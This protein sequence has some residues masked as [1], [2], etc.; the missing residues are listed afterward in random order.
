MCVISAP[1]L[2]AQSNVTTEVKNLPQAT[3]AA[4]SSA[5]QQGYNVRAFGSVGDGKNLDSPAINRAIESCA[6]AGGGTVYVPP[7]TYL[8]GSIRMKS[9][10]HLHIDAGAIILGAPQEMNAYDLAEPFAK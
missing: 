9:N 1:M 10:I 6:Q 8:C 7:G 5:E 2:P 3:A 4:P